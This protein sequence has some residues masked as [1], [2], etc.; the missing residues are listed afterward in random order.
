MCSH[1]ENVDAGLPAAHGREDQHSKEGFPEGL[2]EENTPRVHRAAGGVCIYLFIK[3]KLERLLQWSE[4]TWWSISNVISEM[5]CSIKPL[6]RISR[7]YISL[8]EPPVF[9]YLSFG[10]K[11]RA[12]WFTF[13][14]FFFFS[15]VFLMLDCIIL[16]QFDSFSCAESLSI[17]AYPNE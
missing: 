11:P 9:F 12:I 4:I 13:L 6:K 15:Y 17:T 2:T 14:H 8:K 10:K 1:S 16:S 3:E 7:W 5:Q